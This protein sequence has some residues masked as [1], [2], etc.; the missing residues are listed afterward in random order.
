MVTLG[1]GIAPVEASDTLAD[2]LVTRI[3]R[4]RRRRYKVLVR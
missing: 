1:G 2:P 3:D 4:G